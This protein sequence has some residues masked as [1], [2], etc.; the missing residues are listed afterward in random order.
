[1]AFFPSTENTV[2][3]SM[4]DVTDLLGS[5]SRHGFELDA[6]FWPSVEH[7]VQGLRFE[8]PAVRAAVRACE[9]PHEARRLGDRKRRQQRS[10]WKVLQRTYMTRG[11]WAKVHHHAPVRAA[12]LATGDRPIIETS[13][14]DYFWGCGRDT[15]GDNHYGRI[16]VAVRERLGGSDE[17]PELPT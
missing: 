3:V 6:A 7:Y 11:V 17:H 2:R 5:C 13:Q 10:N 12:L 14:Y 8:D 9:H 15:R 1:M 4:L 16:L